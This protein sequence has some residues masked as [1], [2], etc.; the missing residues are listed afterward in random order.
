MPK[1]YWGEAVFSAAYLQNRLPSRVVS[2]TPFALWT[3]KKPDL[4][5]LRMFGCDAYVQVPEQK[6]SKFDYKAVKL[7][8]IGYAEY[9]KGYRFVDRSTHKVT[10]SRDAKF[11]ELGNG[12]DQVEKRMEPEPTEVLA[13]EVEIPIISRDNEESVEPE[14]DNSGSSSDFEGWAGHGC[15]MI[16]QQKE[17]EIRR[18]ECRET[19]GEIVASCQRITVTS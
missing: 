9:R 15:P 3:G 14:D 8:F 7:S 16:L 2:T 18:S 4:A 10:I 19:L 6:R 11:L 13:P 17:F 5:E 1:L 12:S